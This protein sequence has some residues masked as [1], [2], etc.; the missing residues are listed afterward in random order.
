MATKSKSDI[1]NSAIRIF[2]QSVGSYY[3]EIRGFKRFNRNCPEWDETKYQNINL[4]S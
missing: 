1:S 2:L 4:R 3:D